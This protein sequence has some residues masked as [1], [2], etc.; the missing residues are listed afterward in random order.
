[1][2]NSTITIKIQQNFQIII[3]IQTIK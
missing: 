2:V 3:T 1:M